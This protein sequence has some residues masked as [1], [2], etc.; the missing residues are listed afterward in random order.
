MRSIKIAVPTNDGVTVFPKMLGMAKTFFIY[1][2]VKED[3]EKYSVIKG[4]S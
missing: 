1:E 3:V 2:K 4:K